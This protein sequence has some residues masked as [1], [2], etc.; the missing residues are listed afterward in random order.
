MS[1]VVY[2]PPSPRYVVE[3]KRG[4]LWE[5]ESAHRYLKEAEEAANNLVSTFPTG[6]FRVIDTWATA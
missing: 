4:A 5:P 1:K 6:K 3:E 2:E